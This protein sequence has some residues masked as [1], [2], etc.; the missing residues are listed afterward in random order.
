MRALTYQPDQDRFTLTE[1]PVPTP[2][3]GEVLV[4]VLACGLNPVDA[5]INLWHAQAPGMGAHWVPGLD[6][7]GEIVGLGEGVDGWRLGDSV[8]YHGDMFKPSGG[9]AEFALHSAATLIPMPKV[10]PEEAAA[11]PCAGWTAWRALVDRL[12]LAGKPSLLIAGGAGGVGSFAVQIAR[13]LGV[14]QVVATCSAANADYVRDLGASEVIDYR[15]E[16]VQA[17]VMA[18]TQGHGVAAALDAVGGDND[19]LCASV[20]AYEGQMVELVRTLRPESYP[21]AFMK[22]LGF[23]QLSLGSG[24]RHGLAGQVDLVAA[25]LAFSERLEAGAIRVPRLTRVVLE[26]VG[27]AL[28]AMR[29]QRTVG[30]LVMTH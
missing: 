28:M 7:A 3:P 6:V 23:H 30:K 10:T 5:K 27:E 21:D 22:G 25:G 26:E 29:E 2:G 1:R 8:L 20:L 11:T 18:L 9:Y 4:R 17:R 12:Q 19:I 16:D 14:G 24:H 15:Q 13:D